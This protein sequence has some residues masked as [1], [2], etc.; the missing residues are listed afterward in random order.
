[1]SIG[2]FP[3]LHALAVQQ[4]A[5]PAALER[6]VGERADLADELAGLREHGL[7]AYLAGR[8]LWRITAEGRQR[9]ARL[10]TEDVPPEAHLRL[11]AGYQRFLPLNLA[12]KAACTRWQLRD[13]APNDHGD[14]DYDSAVIGELATRHDTASAVIDELAAVRPRFAR[15]RQRLDDALARLGDGELAAF[16]GVGQGSYHDVWMEL[17]R[18]LLLSLCL[19]RASEEAVSAR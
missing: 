8:D 5:T 6:A 16:T 15:Y 18:D 2:L 17:H 1:M 19:D 11:H 12:V 10:I 13:G 7:A 9:H 4:V 3:V 14:A